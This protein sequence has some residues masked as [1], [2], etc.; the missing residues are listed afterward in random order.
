MGEKPIGVK[1]IAR[2]I[3]V[4]LRRFE[5]DPKINAKDPNY[6]TRPYYHTHAWHGG[7]WVMVQYVSYQGSSSLTKDG[8]LAYLAWLDAG[9][10]GR[11][12][13]FERETKEATR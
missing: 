13:E 1:E 7:P 3:S 9:N 10:V 5:L 6:G 12:Y 8:A 11:H 2:R 4:H